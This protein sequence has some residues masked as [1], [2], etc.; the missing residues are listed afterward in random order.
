MRDI[1]PFGLRLPPE[2]RHS[3][4]VAAGNNRR[5]MNAEI[6]ARLTESFIEKPTEP[7]SLFQLI[8][9]VFKEAEK[10]G[11]PVKV[12]L[13]EDDAEEEQDD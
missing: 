8:E 2:I 9:A 7:K 10:A 5:S 3:V 13:G 4:E 1:N 11:I 12:I 6:I